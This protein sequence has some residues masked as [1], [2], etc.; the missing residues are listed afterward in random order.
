MHG[1]GNDFAVFDAR[2]EPLIM[3]APLA[4]ALA[5]RHTGIGCDQLIVVGPSDKADV[6]MRIWNP[7][8]SEVEACGNASRCVAALV[9]KP[10]TIETRGGLLSATPSGDGASVD[11]GAPRFEWDEIPL[12]YAMDTTAL[13]VGW[14]ILEKPVAINV[15]NPHLVFFVPQVGIVPL[16][17]LGPIIE[18]DA[19]FPRRINVNLGEIISR[20]HIRVRTWE[21]GTGL[22]RACG[23]GAC[24]TAVAAI[25]S[26]LTDSIVTVELPGGRLVIE[27][28]PGE[29]IRM[30]GPAT[31][32]YTGQISLDS[33]R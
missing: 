4:A 10:C 31:L 30:S 24:A 27:W 2:T 25:R 23:T 11:M 17:R 19:L 3:T 6:S 8:G 33:F 13:P 9:G 16:G 1:L 32:A 28:R 22:T 12:A 18:N 21:R 26:G 15:G 5:N 7:D 29:T 20:T 14:E